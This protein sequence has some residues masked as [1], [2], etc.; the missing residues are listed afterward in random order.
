MKH[1]VRTGRRNTTWE[2]ACMSK[3]PANFFP[4]SPPDTHIQNPAGLHEGLQ[5]QNCPFPGHLH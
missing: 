5:G 2:V 4:A 3:H 1:V